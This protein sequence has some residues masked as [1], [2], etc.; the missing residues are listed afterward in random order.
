MRILINRKPVEGP[1]GGG[2]LFVKAF[3]DYFSSL[4]H[5]VVHNMD[6]KVDLMFMQDPRYSDL[7]ISINEIVK[8]KQMNPEVG[9]VHRV[10]ECDARKGT[11]D[12]DTLLRECSKFTDLTIFVSNWM[13][14]YHRKLGWHCKK[15][16][17]V[18]NGVDLDHFKKREKIKNGKT[19]IV[20]HHWSDN[21]LKGSDVY[22]FLDEFVGKNSQEYTFTYIGRSGVE[23]KNTNVVKPLSGKALGQELSK[24][25]VYVSGSR[26][27]PGPNHVIESV[28]CEMPTI[29]HQEG[30]G[31]LEFCG[32]QMSYGTTQELINLLQDI[33]D[34]GNLENVLKP[35]SWIDCMKNLEIAIFRR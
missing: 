1:W 28:A 2:N 9:L 13:E 25:D 16:E 34:E 11:Q 30:G 18:Y 24:Y 5:D 32:P 33:K 26:Y 14:E 22:S 15:S 12:M 21:P 19:N 4:G 27:D 10:N 17:V 35:Y 7:G 20:T 31:A 23:F 3:C 8:Y 29:C 6:Q